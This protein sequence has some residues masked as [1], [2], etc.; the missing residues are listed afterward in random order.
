M[1][2][3]YKNRLSVAKDCGTDSGCFTQNVVRVKSGSIDP[4]ERDGSN[5]YKLIIADGTQLNIANSWTYP[6]CDFNLYGNSNVCVLFQV[7][8]NG[9]KNPNQIGQD[10][11]LFVLK[12]NGLHP[13]GCDS[14]ACDNNGWGCAC[15]V[16]RENAINY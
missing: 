11:F 8:V 15:K 5:F 4:T 6:Q 1:Y 13:S 16:L 14:D 7:D 9:A 12:E 2:N 3:L 10:V